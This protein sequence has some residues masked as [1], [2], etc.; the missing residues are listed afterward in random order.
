MGLK[1]HIVNAATGDSSK[2]PVKES[3]FE[4]STFYQVSEISTTASEST[5]MFRDNSLLSA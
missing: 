3:S 5:G 1:I 2:P 4:I